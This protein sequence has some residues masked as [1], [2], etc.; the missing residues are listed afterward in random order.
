M[1]LEGIERMNATAF[2]LFGFCADG[3]AMQFQ[4]RRQIHRPRP[5]PS[6]RSGGDAWVEF[7]ENV[8][9]LYR[10]DSAAIVFHRQFGSLLSL[11]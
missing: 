6:L 9:Q 8:T 10:W 11:C 7:F 2:A 5:A 4:D 3:T 1:Q